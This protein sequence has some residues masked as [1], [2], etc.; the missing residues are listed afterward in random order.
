MTR[1]SVFLDPGKFRR[2]NTL[3]RSHKSALAALRAPVGQMQGETTMAYSQQYDKEERR[4]RWSAAAATLCL[5]TGWA[6]WLRRAALLV[7]C[8]LFFEYATLLAPCAARI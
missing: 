4:S 6:D 3:N 2:Y 5:T 8:V 7:V 1:L